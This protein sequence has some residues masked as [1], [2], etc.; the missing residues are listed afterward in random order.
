MS[1]ELPD[2]GRRLARLVAVAATSYTVSCLLGVGLR[3]G[4]LRDPRLRWIHHA[5]Y[6]STVSTTGAAATAALATRSPTG[7]PL[8]PALA[9]LAAL[10]RVSTRS[11]RHPLV[12]LSLLPCYL[13]SAGLAARTR[14]RAG[15]TEGVTW[16]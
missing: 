8:L 16:S 10:S 4:L 2:G 1:A 11:R 5:G 12:A 15:R 7:W 14:R 6:I 3:T 9:G 13:A